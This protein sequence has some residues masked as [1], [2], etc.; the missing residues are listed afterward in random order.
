MKDSKLW[1]TFIRGLLTSVLIIGAFSSCAFQ[2]RLNTVDT[3]PMYGQPSIPRS[4]IQQQDDQKFIMEAAVSYGSREE[5][6]KAWHKKG[7]VFMQQYAQNFNQSNLD[8]AM[9][10]YN[11]AWILDPNNYQPYWGFARVLIEKSQSGQAIEYFERAKTL[12]NDPYQESALLSD[13]GTAYTVKAG[14]L[15]KDQIENQKKYFGLANENFKA[16][17]TLD[18][19]Y[20]KVWPRWVWS[21]YSQNNYSEAWEKVKKGRAV[22]ASFP[23][24]LL[25]QLN[26]EM[27]EPQ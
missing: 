5:A 26:N 23:S 9:K 16:S 22:N 19:T 12:I 10:R 15:S 11:Q 21:L 14:D 8:Y 27:P 24:K 18:P 25:E 3:L 1:L 2:Q 13:L 4:A 17:L 7:E 20:T 6:S